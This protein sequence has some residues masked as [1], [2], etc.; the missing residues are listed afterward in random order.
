MDVA[1]AL[2]FFSRELPLRVGF[3]GVL[4]CDR[5]LAPSARRSF[6]CF[7][8][9]AFSSACLESRFAAL[10][11]GSDALALDSLLACLLAS[12]EHKREYDD[13]GDDQHDDKS[14]A[15]VVLPSPGR[16]VNVLGRLW[17]VS[18]AGHRF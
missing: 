7:G 2:L 6:L 16:P 15:H 18:F 8:L 1:S 9:R 14:R 11:A 3:D 4:L 10:L 13:R 5:A 12:S 17:R